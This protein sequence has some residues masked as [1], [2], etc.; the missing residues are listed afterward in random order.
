MGPPGTPGLNGVPG[1]NGFDGVDGSQGRPVSCT[2]NESWPQYNYGG[3]FSWVAGVNHFC[4]YTH[5]S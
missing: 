1:T 5:K 3:K 4:V 2:C